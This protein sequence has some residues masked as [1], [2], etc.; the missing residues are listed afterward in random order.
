MNVEV[1]LRLFCEYLLHLVL[2][3]QLFNEKIIPAPQRRRD[4]LE[5]SRQA[6]MK[7]VIVTQAQSEKADRILDHYRDSPDLE[8][9]HPGGHWTKIELS[10]RD[11]RTLAPD[12]WLNDNVIDFYIRCHAQEAMPGNL[13]KEGGPELRVLLWQTQFWQFLSG[14]VRDPV[15]T[16]KY[17]YA[18]VRRW[19]TR[20]KV[21]VFGVDLMIVPVGTGNHWSVGLLDFR[22][23]TIYYFCSCGWRKMNFVSH[24]K[25]YL[26][27]EW[28][29]KK[30]KTGASKGTTYSADDWK[31]VW[32]V[33]YPGAGGVPKQVGADD[34]GVFTCLFVVS[35][36][37][38]YHADQM[39]TLPKFDFSADQMEDWRRRILLE[40]FSGEIEQL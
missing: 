36:L 12:T 33:A 8:K 25:K 24:M 3:H 28:G 5:T 17:D 14:E 15:D 1:V 16:P 7:K 9:V 11:M 26:K 29:D 10:A 32:P 6:R 27:D 40:I 21:D 2:A 18:K 34:C 19:S 35:I 39:E 37:K 30:A 23:K 22:S 13:F 38:A 20:R 31:T 4:L